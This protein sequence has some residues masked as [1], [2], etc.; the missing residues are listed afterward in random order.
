MLLRIA[1]VRSEAAGCPT[2]VIEA[3]P[4]V[5]FSQ[6]ELLCDAGAGPG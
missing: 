4:F 1:S 6:R 5:Q 3:R 2:T